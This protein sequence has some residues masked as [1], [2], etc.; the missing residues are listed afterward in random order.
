ML[1]SKVGPFSWSHG[2]KLLS[3]WRATKPKSATCPTFFKNPIK[4]KPN[5]L[6]FNSNYYLSRRCHTLWMECSIPAQ[7]PPRMLPRSTN[8]KKSSCRK[9]LFS[10]LFVSFGSIFCNLCDKWSNQWR[11]CNRWWERRPKKVDMEGDRCLFPLSPLFILCSVFLFRVVL[12]DLRS[13]RAR[14]AR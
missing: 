9:S 5:L 14:S 3:K 1:G 7:P 13:Q 12:R 8:I 10:L 4:L 2:L 11:R 6:L